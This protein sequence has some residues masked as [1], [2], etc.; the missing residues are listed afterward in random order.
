MTDRTRTLSPTRRRVLAG[1]GA[2]PLLAG[3][4]ARAATR[5]AD[6]AGER[7]FDAVPRRLVALNWA[8]AEQLIEL[9]APPVG[10]ADPAGYTEWVA[11]PAL[12]ADIADVGKRDAPNLERIAGLAPDAV[13][14][15]GEQSAFR[16]RLEPIAPVLHFD[17]FRE[18]HDNAAVARATLLDLGGLLERR[19]LAESKLAAMDARLAALKA[20]IADAY[21]GNPPRV[22]LI[23]FIDDKR[24]VIYTANGMPAAALEALGLHS[25]YPAPPSRWGLAFK[26][27]TELAVID[28]GLVLHIE[29]FPAAGELFPTALWQAMPF[30]AEGRFG[31]L[32]TLWTYG[33]AMSIGRIGEAIA[34]ELLFRRSR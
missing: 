18:N 32:P 25:A 9:E 24:V 31:S 34:A 11:R 2:L 19:D 8:L 14:I 10:I 7:E 27:V 3:G 12:P 5:I 33:G 1:L 29:P 22:T 16:P 17:P 13:L 30:V 26:P 15:A 21:D 23:R 4:R 20:E 6:S 28:E